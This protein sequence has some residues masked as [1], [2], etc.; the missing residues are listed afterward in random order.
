MIGTSMLTIYV[1]LRIMV[2]GRGCA[3]EKKLISVCSALQQRKSSRVE[4]GRFSDRKVKTSG[5]EA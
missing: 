3:A 4:V 5:L 2:V 1:G